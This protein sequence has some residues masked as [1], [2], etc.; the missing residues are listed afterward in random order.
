MI[1]IYKDYSNLILTFEILKHY[2]YHEQVSVSVLCFYP[3]LYWQCI[4]ILWWTWVCTNQKEFAYRLR[5]L[6]TSWYD[7][8]CFWSWNGHS[9]KAE[10]ISALSWH[11]CLAIRC[12]RLDE[13]FITSLNIVYINCNFKNIMILSV[14]C[15]FLPPFLFSFSSF[16][17]SFFLSFWESVLCINITFIWEWIILP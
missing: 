6:L 3:S 10:K 16:V 14:L 12:I 13:D 17:H 15:V 7:M 5:Y 11:Y 2:C 4:A 1:Y 8:W 9:L